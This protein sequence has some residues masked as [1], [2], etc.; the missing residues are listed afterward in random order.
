M[1]SLHHMLHISKF[2]YV[3]YGLSFCL[4]QDETVKAKESFWSS[5]NILKKKRNMLWLK[6]IGQGHSKP[7]K[8]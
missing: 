6:T 5:I 8:H 1:Q 4:A 3:N 2:M 7:S